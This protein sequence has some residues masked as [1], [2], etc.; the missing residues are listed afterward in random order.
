MGMRAFLPSNAVSVFAFP[1]RSFAENRLRIKCAVEIHSSKES[2]HCG[3]SIG[4]RFG[5]NLRLQD[6]PTV[7][8]TW[9]LTMIVTWGTR[10]QRKL[11]VS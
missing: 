11:E 10:Y 9:M 5:Q 8:M 4:T 2:A 7:D 3:L 6:V 1:L